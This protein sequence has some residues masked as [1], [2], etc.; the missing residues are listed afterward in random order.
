MDSPASVARKMK[1]VQEECVYTSTYGISCPEITDEELEKGQEF[2]NEWLEEYIDFMKDYTEELKNDDDK[3]FNV[4]FWT[5]V[6]SKYI[7]T[8]N[9]I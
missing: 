8:Q 7:M 1:I 6:C 9:R 5:P 2:V 4:V 3:L